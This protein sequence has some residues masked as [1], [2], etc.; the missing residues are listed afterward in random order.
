[1]HYRDF[2][3]ARAVLA[4]VAVIAALGQ[5]APTLAAANA[6][7]PAVIDA[8]PV[9]LT[10]TTGVELKHRDNIYLQDMVDLDVMYI[11]FEFGDRTFLSFGFTK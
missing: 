7:G 1:M 5:T 11:F 4:L 3:S 9:A 2:V 10:P 8:G 6:V